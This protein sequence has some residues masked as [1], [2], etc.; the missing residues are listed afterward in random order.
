MA[1]LN[2]AELNNKVKKDFLNYA[3]AVIKSRAISNVEDNLKPVHRRILFAMSELD[4]ASNKKHKKSARIVG[5]IIGKYHP[6]GD[7]SA[8]EAMVRLS[9]KWK[10]RYPLVEMQGNSGNILGDGAAAMRYTEARLTPFGDLML[11]GIEKRG[12][13]FKPTYDESSEEPILMPSIF[14]NILCNGNAG[15]AVG[16]ST[17]LVPHNLKEVVNAINAYIGFKSITIEAIMKHLPGP[18]FPTGGTIVDA[19]V[20]KD[21]YT[22][23]S[24][25]VTLR[26]KYAIE[27][28]KGQQHIVIT[29]VPYLVGIEDGV[30]E[31]LKRLVNEDGFDLIE[32]YENNTG[33]DGVN[34][35][36]ILKKGANIYKV[37][38]TLWKETRLQITQRI[39]NTVIVAGNPVVLNIKEMIEHYVEHRHN[40]LSNIAKNDLDKTQKR[41]LIVLGLLKALEKI[42]EVIALI[43]NA[44][45]KGDARNKLISFLEIDEIQANAILDMRLSRINQLDGAEL[46][47]E[48]ESLKKSEKELQD[49]LNFSSVRDELIRRE[50]LVLSNKYGD[51]RRTVLTHQSADNPV[52]APVQNIKVL[53]YDNGSVF[54]TQQKLSAL[55]IKRKGST[56]NSTAISLV[57]DT[58]TDKTITVFTKDGS[59]T[60][61]RI[62]TLSTEN[63]EFG[64]FSST[65][66]AAF[67]FSD[68]ST[69]KD[70]IIFITSGGLVKKTKTEEYLNAK[71]GS[72]T[73]KLK[74]DQELIFVGTANDDDNIM[75]L[76][77]KLTYFKVSDVTSG[78]KITI[79]S[80][81]ISTNHAISAAVIGDNEKVL[82]IN[83][84]GQGKMTEASD[85]TYSAKGSNGQ[86]IAENTVL[87][88]K[89]SAEYF[90]FSGGKNNLITSNP[91]IK[92]KSA[93]GSK[94]VTGNP[95]S[96]SN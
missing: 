26:S 7:T 49:I 46:R 59:L 91:A 3:N 13:N 55:D 42:D 67:D 29:E 44:K 83:S 12:V 11:S 54:A 64:L 17:S 37:L 80:K 93:V 86:V 18:D 62:L 31:P 66:L 28:V 19:G 69:L 48:L 30:I 60:H 65:P 35:R 78:S 50:L 1:A 25:T 38:E 72:R 36:I 96:I 22:S 41:I 27:T 63:L 75:I 40:V 79:G 81:G 16:L 45:D 24:G 21:I 32:D 88:A 47:N 56:L 71:T 43:K 73:I 58:K 94:L 95:I 68:K 61:T 10:M 9:Q 14:P 84:S 15:I 52:D 20:I 70:Y 82:M 76:D 23:G 89:E 33:K 87:I 8:Y 2:K 4:L 34:L 39:S 90:V 51:D 5:D 77:E 92:S 6:H 85:F 53:M 74:G 57:T